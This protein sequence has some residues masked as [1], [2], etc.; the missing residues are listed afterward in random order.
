V[1]CCLL[2]ENI[3]FIIFNGNFFQKSNVLRNHIPLF[4]LTLFRQTQYLS[5]SHIPSLTGRWRVF[6][7]PFSTNILSLTGHL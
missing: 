4:V 3:S 1:A 7:I 2:L 6:G 5:Y